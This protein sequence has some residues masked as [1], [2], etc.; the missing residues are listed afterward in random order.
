LLLSFAGSAALIAA[1]E[2]TKGWPSGP[3]LHREAKRERP[4]RSG[5]WRKPVLLLRAAKAGSPA[6]G[7]EPGAAIAGTG[8][9][10]QK[11]PS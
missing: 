8:R 10:P 2:A 1:F 11:S 6:G 4:K 5:G 7:K 3:D 9:L